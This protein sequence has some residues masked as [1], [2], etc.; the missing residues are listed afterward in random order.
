[1]NKRGRPPKERF[2]HEVVVL[3]LL[4]PASVRDL[5]DA[6]GAID[7]VAALHV[8][9]RVSLLRATTSVVQDFRLISELAKHPRSGRGNKPK[10]QISMLLFRC[11]EVWASATKTKSVS[12]WERDDGT[13]ESPPV[14]I[15][16]AC[17]E[18]VLGK[19]Y[20]FSLRQQISK[21]PNW[22]RMAKR[23][24]GISVELHAMTEAEPS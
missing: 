19:P 9:D 14:Q 10:A 24:E 15:A 18:F 16:R 20:K 2:E 21:A 7:C 8:R 23:R 6:I 13:K 1:M 17:L 5:H 22:Q 3:D 4:D 12:L 11:A